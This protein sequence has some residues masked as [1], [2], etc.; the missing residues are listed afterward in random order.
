MNWLRLLKSCSFT[1]TYEVVYMRG[2]FSLPLL[3]AFMKHN[4]A[5]S[6]N[7]AMRN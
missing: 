2:Y 3:G 1:T 5:I 4:E 7:S 6:F